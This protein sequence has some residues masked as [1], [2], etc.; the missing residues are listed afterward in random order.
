MR[1]ASLLAAWAADTSQDLHDDAALRRVYCI[2]P[3]GTSLAKVA[4]PMHAL[5]RP[6]IEAAPFAV[7]STLGVQGLDSSPRGDTPGS[8]KVV[9][10]RTWRVGRAARQRQRAHQRPARPVRSPGGGRQGARQRARHPR[11]QRVLPMR[12][13]H[14]TEGLWNPAQHIAA[15]TLPSPG[16]I[17]EYLSAQRLD[18][19]AHDAA[20]QARQASTLC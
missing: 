17:L 12:A 15:G 19:A 4:E 8:V 16:A 1:V 14:Q 3:S 9:V 5:Y 7:L 13:G 6:C 18:G 2:G 11:A 10:A 20:L